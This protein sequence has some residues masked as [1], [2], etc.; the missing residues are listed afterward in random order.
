MLL[1]ANLNGH[2][3]ALLRVRSILFPYN[4]EG[5]SVSNLDAV[6][7]LSIRHRRDNPARTYATASLDSLK[8]IKCAYRVT[9]Q[10]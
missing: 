8:F 9:I 10:D 4:D 6:V 5:S 7:G 3:T 2:Q 1:V